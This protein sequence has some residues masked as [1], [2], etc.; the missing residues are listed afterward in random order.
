[1]TS[2]GCSVTACHIK[3][4]LTYLQLPTDNL[5]THNTIMNRHVSRSLVSFTGDMHKMTIDTPT[6]C[7][8][9][10]RAMTGVCVCVCACVCVCVCVCG[11]TL[12][13]DA[14]RHMSG[15]RAH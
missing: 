15:N 12:G 6:A 7:R 4:H 11:C 10:V 1:M 13:K 8:T 14:V 9:T 3:S 2:I 5:A